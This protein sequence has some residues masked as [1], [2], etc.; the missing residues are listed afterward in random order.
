MN[1][2]GR[3]YENKINNFEFLFKSQFFSFFLHTTGFSLFIL[4]A[5]AASMGIFMDFY[6]NLNKMFVLLFLL[7]NF[8][9][10]FIL[11]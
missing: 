4:A 5:A 11:V 10:I 6:K 2:K 8:K 3:S 7:L 9:F 1:I